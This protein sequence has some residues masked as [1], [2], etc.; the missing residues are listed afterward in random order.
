[1]FTFSHTWKPNVATSGSRNKSTKTEL[2]KPKTIPPS[3]D[4]KNAIVASIENAPLAISSILFFPPPPPGGRLYMER[5][6]AEVQGR[7]SWMSRIPYTDFRGEILLFVDNFNGEETMAPRQVTWL[8]F[9]VTGKIENAF[10][11]PPKN[12]GPKTQITKK[13]ASNDKEAC[14]VILL[15]YFTEA[16]FPFKKNP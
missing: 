14:F 7:K 15:P 5:P 2:N 8:C 12:D 16:L 6:V 10:E 3:G 4:T 1:M 9:N 13:N 11:Y